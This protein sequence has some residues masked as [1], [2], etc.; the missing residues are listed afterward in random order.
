MRN[1]AGSS[2]SEAQYISVQDVEYELAPGCARTFE[3]KLLATERLEIRQM[4]M[5]GPGDG[6][7][8]GSC[9][10]ARA[11]YLLE[12]SAILKDH[13]EREVG[14]GQLIV[15]PAG[16]RWEEQLSLLSGELVLLEVARAG[17][18]A[19][20][21]SQPPA[22]VRVV[23]PEEVEPYE[24]AG[25][26]KTRNRCLF[27]DEYME[28]VR[29]SIE[30]GG[31]AERHSHRDHEQLLYLLGGA[32]EALLIH[33]PKGVPHGTGGGVAEPLELLV[34]YSPPLGESQNALG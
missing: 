5:K 15:I 10:T 25:H 1:P 33:Y 19:V 7:D 20:D 27:I 23:D 28:I 29:G 30:R 26:A 31:G 34:I 13:D 11:A 8:R 32:G 2:G 9:A 12:G 18:G 6:E 4:R 17:L 16:A 24:P 3:K 21:S 14:E 22:P